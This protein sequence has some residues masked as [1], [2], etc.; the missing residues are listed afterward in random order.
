MK[1]FASRPRQD[2]P[3]T[4]LVRRAHAPA[5]LAQRDGEWTLWS[6]QQLAHL[7]FV[8]EVPPPRTQADDRT[9]VVE[10]AAEV[11]DVATIDEDRPLRQIEDQVTAPVVLVQ[12]NSAVGAQCVESAGGI[13]PLVGTRRSAERAR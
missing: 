11:R 10:H 5:I 13:G 7:V 4:R 1:T 9:V 8:E 3:S 2:D 6:E 12:E